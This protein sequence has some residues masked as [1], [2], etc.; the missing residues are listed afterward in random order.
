MNRIIKF[1]LSILFL[2]VGITGGMLYAGTEHI[3]DNAKILVMV[4]Y[5]LW[6]PNV[7]WANKIFHEQSLQDSNTE[8]I[9][10]N[11]IETV[12]S[13]VKI[14]QFK[15]FQLPEEWQKEN[16]TDRI[17]WGKK[18]ESMLRNWVLPRKKRWNLD[19]TWNW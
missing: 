4:E 17:F 12:Y 16:E 6:I 14:G 2:F 3:Q 1:I 10:R 18:S 19:G 5:Q 11:R 13:E 8:R 15:G 9:F 7:D